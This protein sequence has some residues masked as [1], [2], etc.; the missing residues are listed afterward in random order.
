MP[1]TQER[2]ARVARALVGKLPGKERALPARALLGQGRAL[3]ARVTWV[4]QERAMSLLASGAQRGA[5]LAV[6]VRWP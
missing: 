4:Q 1:E 5:S 3:P 2:R 6:R